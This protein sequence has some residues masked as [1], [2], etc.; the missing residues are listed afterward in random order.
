MDCIRPATWT[1]DL[2]CDLLFLSACSPWTEFSSWSW[3]K[4]VVQIM[5]SCSLSL[6]L[7][8]AF[9]DIFSHVLALS[10][11]NFLELSLKKKDMVW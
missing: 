3:M 2:L 1:S 10:F 5:F 11:V 4:H 8:A 6:A 7:P 9:S